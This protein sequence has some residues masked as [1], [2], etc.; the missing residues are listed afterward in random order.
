[1]AQ[2]REILPDSVALGFGSIVAAAGL[3]FA[4]YAYLHWRRKVSESIAMGESEEEEDEGYSFPEAPDPLS[5]ADWTPVPV[6]PAE[7]RRADGR[8]GDLTPAKQA[9]L[10]TIQGHALEARTA[11]AYQRLLLAARGDG[12]EAPYLNLVSGYRSPQSQMVLYNKALTKYRGKL[13]KSLGREPSDQEVEKEARRWVAAPGSSSHQTGR[14][15]DLNLGVSTSS[16]N[17]EK[18]RNTPAYKWLREHAAQFGF[19]PYAPEPWHWEYNP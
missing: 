8:I 5:E 2:R 15:L 9:D 6:E 18:A 16:E 3:G 7:K 14:A 10:V 19:Y 11:D 1:M 13:Q 17:V 12:I 4:A